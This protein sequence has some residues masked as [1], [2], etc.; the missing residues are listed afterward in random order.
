MEKEE[1]S[2]ER[3]KIDQKVGKIGLLKVKGARIIQLGGEK[4]VAGL[5]KLFSVWRFIVWRLVFS[6]L[7]RREQKARSFTSAGGGKVG[8][9]EEFPKSEVKHWNGLL[10]S[11]FFWRCLEIRQKLIWE[12][13]FKWVESCL[14]HQ[15]ITQMTCGCP[16]SRCRAG[17]DFATGLIF[18]VSNCYLVGSSD[19]C[20]G[21][22]EVKV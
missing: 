22:K 5:I 18:L 19:W 13:W 9:R 4:L 1:N 15:S 20:R 7:L 10:W 16:F 2:E 12:E 3:Q 17:V 11:L 14:W 6:L 21:G 8:C